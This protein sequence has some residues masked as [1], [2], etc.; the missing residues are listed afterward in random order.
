MW[1]FQF[2]KQP[3]ASFIEFFIEFDSLLDSM[4]FGFYGVGGFLGVEIVVSDVVIFVPD[5]FQVHFAGEAGIEDV[6][7][8]SGFVLFDE[9]S[10]AHR[11]VSKYVSSYCLGLL[12][13]WSGML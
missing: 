11:Q 5:G 1:Y 8:L 9:A 4:A 3:L 6:H 10:Y 7:R 2:L 12:P 13:S